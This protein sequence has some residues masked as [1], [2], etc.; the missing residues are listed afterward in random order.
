MKFKS[1]T[2]QTEAIEL[3]FSAVMFIMLYKVVLLSFLWIN[4]VTI[5]MIAT[6]QYFPVACLLYCARLVLI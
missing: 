1:V 5:Q 6:E 4:S 2:I 3:Y